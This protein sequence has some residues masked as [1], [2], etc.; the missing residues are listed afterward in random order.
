[1]FAVYISLIEYTQTKLCH[2]NVKYFFI[3]EC[4]LVLWKND[5]VSEKYDFCWVKI[6]VFY[7]KF[8]SFVL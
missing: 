7:R 3:I 2:N 6:S 5:F 1:M 4:F 8:Q